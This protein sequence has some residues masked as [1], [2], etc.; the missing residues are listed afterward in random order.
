MILPNV[1][2]DSYV[3]KKNVDSYVN[4]DSYIYVYKYTYES[5]FTFGMIVFW[6]LCVFHYICACTNITYESTFTWKTHRFQKMILPNVNVDSYVYL[7]TH[8]QKHVCWKTHWTFYIL[9]NTLEEWVVSKETYICENMRK[10]I[11]L[12]LAGSPRRG[13]IP[14]SVN[15]IFG[16]MGLQ[17]ARGGKG[18]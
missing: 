15:W 8:V 4:V 1:N 17:W 7:Y 6:N 14:L 3:Y 16:V 11:V 5:T 10:E 2:V 9:K 13:A 18:L 12:A